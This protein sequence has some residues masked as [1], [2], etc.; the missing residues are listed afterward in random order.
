MSEL[1]AFDPAELARYAR[2]IRLPEFGLGGQERL[3]AA[4]ALVVG[5][6]G[7]GSPAAMYL[8]A[9]GIGRLDLQ[10]GATGRAKVGIKGKGA[11]LDVPALPVASLPV[12]AQLRN[13]NGVCWS[14]TFS[15]TRRND[16]VQLKAS[17]D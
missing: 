2:Q 5:A 12:T 17:S 8:A 3:K 13:S 4:S 11:Q 9:A 10:A 7:L 15:T 14:S 1:E 16:G 6:G